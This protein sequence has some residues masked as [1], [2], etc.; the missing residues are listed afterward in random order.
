MDRFSLFRFRLSLFYF[1]QAAF[2]LLDV[3]IFTSLC[4]TEGIYWNPFSLFCEIPEV[5]YLGVCS[6]RGDIH[7]QTTTDSVQW[8]LGSVFLNVL[9]VSCVTLW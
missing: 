4:L 8:T 2:V 9:D 6:F 3:S 1:Y 5:V 7:T